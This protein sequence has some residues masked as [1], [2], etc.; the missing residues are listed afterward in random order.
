MQVL[1]VYDVRFGAARV[2]GPEHDLGGLGP[3][4]SRGPGAALQM[5]LRGR[6]LQQHRVLPSFH[7]SQFSGLENFATFGILSRI[8]PWCVCSRAYVCMCVS[9][10]LDVKQHP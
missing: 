2:A 8:I 3:R 10:S 5:L 7:S 4:A 9:L 1:V 6:A